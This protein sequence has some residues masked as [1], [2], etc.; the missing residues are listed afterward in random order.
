MS[1]IRSYINLWFEGNYQK[2]HVLLHS[3]KDPIIFDLSPGGV[4]NFGLG[5]DVRPE[6]STTTL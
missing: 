3:L 1:D 5:T 2:T 4:L 6:G